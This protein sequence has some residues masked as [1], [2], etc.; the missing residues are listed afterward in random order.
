[1]I[2]NMTAHTAEVEGYA[3]LF[4]LTDGDN[5]MVTPGAFA[6][7]LKQK[8]PF[9]IK[10][11][12]QHDPEQLI[13]VWHTIREDARGLYVKGS[14]AIEIEQARD[15]DTLINFNALDGLS[16][17]FQTV[18][19]HRNNITG[20]RKLLEID[21]WE[22]SIVTFPLLPGARIIKPAPAPVL[23]EPIPEPGPGLIGEKYDPLP[24]HVMASTLQQAANNITHH[25]KGK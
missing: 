9:A 18:R 3:S 8:H 2:P 21:L 19:A 4:H 17:G 13:G 24:W 22:I 23:S 6:K 25:L 20:I 14:L 10:M 12:Y 1:M 7:S 15:I 11:L 5:D 16:I